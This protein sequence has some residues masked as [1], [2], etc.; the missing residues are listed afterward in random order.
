LTSLPSVALALFLGRTIA[1]D[2]VLSCPSPSQLGAALDRLLPQSPDVARQVVEL[3]EDQDRLLLTL[4]ELSGRPIGQRVLH[5]SGTCEADA[6]TVAVV[7]AVWEADLAPVTV[8]TPPPASAPPETPAPVDTQPRPGDIPAAPVVPRVRFGGAVGAGASDAAGGLA[9]AGLLRGTVRRSWY[10]AELTL[11]AEGQ[12]TIPLSTGSLFWDRVVAT[13]G[14]ELTPVDQLIR[15][16]LVP[17]VSVALLNVSTSG[18]MSNVNG[19]YPDLG[20]GGCARATLASDWLRPWVE[21]SA[22]GWPMSHQVA[23]PSAQSPVGL[24]TWNLL[25]SIGVALE[26]GP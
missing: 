12:R 20:L 25:F 6:N 18:L 10:G 21:L 13:A 9:V 11:W 23:L 24:P 4:R 17:Q 19:L 26:E 15:L 5:S 16:D 22:F 3:R 1:I 7:V 8:P 2:D 14:V